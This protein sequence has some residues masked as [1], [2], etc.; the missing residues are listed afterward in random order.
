M[1]F[2]GQHA[3]NPDKSPIWFPPFRLDPAHQRL[4]HGERLVPLP[5]KAFAILSYLLD[6]PGQ[7]V[8]HADLLA[9][10]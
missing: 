5:P 4:W 9:R 8:P 7:L 6:Q 3:A 2:R 10:S 1:E